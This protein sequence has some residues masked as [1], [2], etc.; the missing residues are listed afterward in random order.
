METT[1]VYWGYIGVM[2]TKLE[3]STVYW[4]W[5]YVVA[6]E[7]KM[8]NYYSI[9]GL[10]RDNGKENGHYDL[11]I[12]QKPPSPGRVCDEKLQHSISSGCLQRQDAEKTRS[13]YSPWF[14]LRLKNTRK[15]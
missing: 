14:R 11:E 1:I 10:Y 8:E 15:T 2:E 6:M 3:T 9:S 4:D 13:C 5:D 12:I 7:K